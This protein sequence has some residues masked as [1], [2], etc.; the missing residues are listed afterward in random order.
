LYFG[1]LW[2]G[3]WVWLVLAAAAAA[4]ADRM[5]LLL[6]V[7][8]CYSLGPAKLQFPCHLYYLSPGKLSKYSLAAKRSGVFAELPT[9]AAPDAVSKTSR[10][11]K[12]LVHSAKQH[13]WLVFFETVGGA[14]TAGVTDGSRAVSDSWLWTM[15]TDSAAAAA[16]EG[17]WYLPGQ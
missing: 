17:R 12:Q 10:E 13:A 14:V 7:C 1:H 8:C 11:A 4:A 9:A 2:C 15:V 6:I 16:G 5:L 3:E